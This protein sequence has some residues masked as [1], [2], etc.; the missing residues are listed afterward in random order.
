MRVGQVFVYVSTA[1]FL[2]G[3]N[4]SCMGGLKF[5]K[6]SVRQGSLSYPRGPGLTAL[7]PEYVSIDLGFE[8]GMADGWKAS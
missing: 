6:F 4:G 3:N 1:T 8:T 5:R 2:S 7:N